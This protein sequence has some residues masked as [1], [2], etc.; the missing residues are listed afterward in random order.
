MHEVKQDGRKVYIE[1][2]PRVSWANGE[3]CEFASCLVSAMK[4]LGEDAA[5]SYVMGVSGAAFRFALEP[6]NWAFSNWGITNFTEDKY[7]P[8]RRAFSAVGHSYRVFERGEPDEDRARIMES[9]ECGVP[10][11]AFGVIPTADCSIITGYDEGG[12]VLLGWSTFQDIPDDHNHPHDPLGYMRKPDWH[13]DTRGYILIGGTTERRPRRQVYLD[14]LRWA[15][16]VARTPRV[17]DRYTGLAALDVFADEMEDDRYFP[18][19]NPDVIGH[20]YLSILCNLMM[21]DDHKSASPFL[22]Q[23]VDGEFDLGPEVLRAAES[24]EHVS[25]LRGNLGKLLK[26]DFSPEQQAKLPDPKFRRW[27]ALV[28]REIKYAED[29]AIRQLEQIVRR[30]E[31]EG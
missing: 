25:R 9:I 29:Q 7:E 28:I 18:S 5:Y 16:E 8:I 12:D 6:K 20:R 15:I 3:M 26:E 30:C 11:I 10:V 31:R 19:N 23:V 1:D 2:V 13:A 17:G 24:Y 4:C 22:K 14:A 27:Y 21:L